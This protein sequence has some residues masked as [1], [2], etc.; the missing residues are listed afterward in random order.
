MKSP[1][2]R[3][4]NVIGQLEAID[5]MMDDDKS[6]DGVIVQLKAAKSALASAT[7]SYIEEQ[8]QACVK[9]SKDPKRAAR[10]LG[11][12]IRELAKSN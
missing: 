6:C 7:S 8:A 4:R 2:A 10:K 1:Q 12:F 9:N 3:I 5:R 11:M